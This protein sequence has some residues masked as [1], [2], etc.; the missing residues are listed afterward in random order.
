MENQIVKNKIKFLL[1]LIFVLMFFAVSQAAHAATVYFNSSQTSAGI[2]NEFEVRLLLDTAGENINAIEGQILFP[3]D[4]LSLVDIREGD[5]IVDIWLQKPA[6]SQEN[7]IVFSGITPGGFS[8]VYEPLNP[9][10]KFGKIL[11][12][13]FKAR[14]AGQVLFEQQNVRVLLNDGKGTPAN[15]TLTPLI[16]NITD[17]PGILSEQMM[18]DITPPEPF[19]P[20]IAM[21]PAIYNGKYF[22]V[23][24]TQDKGTGV[25]HYE[26]REGSGNFVAAESPYLLRNQN[27]DEEVDIKAVDKSGNERTAIIYPKNPR[28]WYKKY[29]VLFIIIIAAFAY[30]AWGLF[31]RKKF[32]PDEKK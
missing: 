9:D 2:N 23:F 12:M 3:S 18:P 28:P 31:L 8:G 1:P 4:S 21:D 13:I 24:S 7:S 25:D 5:S 14:K 17:Q 26:I 20:E 22:V 15:S 27:L 32:I 16:M 19:F 30:A 29:F 6:L 10:K 11:S